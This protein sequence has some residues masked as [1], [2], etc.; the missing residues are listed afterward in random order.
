PAVSLEMAT[1]PS[2]E[3]GTDNTAGDLMASRPAPAHSGRASEVKDAVELP[4]SPVAAGLETAN[5]LADTKA[6]KVTLTGV[7]GTPGV[8][9]ALEMA[10]TAPATPPAG[11]AAA[12]PG[13]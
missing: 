10:A 13:E 3:H 7:T 5:K 8:K 9:R 4:G 6:P 12:Q 1:V 2:Q 11:P